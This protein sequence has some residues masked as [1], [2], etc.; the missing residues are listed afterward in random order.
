MMTT[1]EALLILVKTSTLPEQIE[2]IDVI[3]AA[4]EVGGPAVSE[5]QNLR[6][7]LRSGMT[8]VLQIVAGRIDAKTQKTVREMFGRLQGRCAKCLEVVEAIN[9]EPTARQKSK[10]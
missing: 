2:S 1:K 3:V 7:T 10:K 4:L 5:I 8:D 9:A 6:E